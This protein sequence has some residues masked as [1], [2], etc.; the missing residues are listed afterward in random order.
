MEKKKKLKLTAT[1]FKEILANDP[2]YN[3]TYLI[4]KGDWEAMLTFLINAV[5]DRYEEAKAEGYVHA[6]K[7]LKNTWRYLVKELKPYESEPNY[8][9]FA[10]LTAEEK[11]S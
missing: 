1:K 2:N 6:A 11:E 5:H 7:S 3:V 4:K 10:T 9:C 8:E